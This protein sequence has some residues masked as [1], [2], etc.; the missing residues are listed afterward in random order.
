M[1]IWILR[2]FKGRL[3]WL[4]GG[5]SILAVAAFFVFLIQKIQ[6]TNHKLGEMAVT[7]KAEREARATLEADYQALIHALQREK[8][9]AETTAAAADKIT[10]DIHNESNQDRP[11][12]PVLRRAVDSLRS[13]STASEH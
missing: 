7:L 9:E 2:S 3:K 1:W 11:V 13:A 4:L 8:I 6:N 10:R 12:G 5:L